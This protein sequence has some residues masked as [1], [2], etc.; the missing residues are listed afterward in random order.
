MKYDVLI[1]GG[2][3][4]GLVSAL[5]LSKEGLRVVVLEQHHKAGGNL[6]TF[7]RDG[8]IF[9]TGM[10]YLG[11][12]REGQYLHRYFKY[13]ELNDKLNLRQLDL[14]GF[15]TITFDGDEEEYQMSQSYAMFIDGL[16]Q[17]FPEEGKALSAYTRKIRSVIEQFPLYNISGTSSYHLNPSLLQECAAGFIKSTIRNPRLQNIL[18]GALSLYPGHADTTPLYVHACMRDSL[19]NSCWRPVDG[20]QQIADGLVK[21]IIKYGGEVMLSRRVKEIMTDKGVASGVLLEDGERISAKRIISNVHPAS[22]LQ[23]IGEGEIKKFYRRRIMRMK[24]TMGVFTV[25]ASL[26]ENSFPYLNKNYF[27]YTNNGVLDTTAKDQNWPENYYFYTP[28]TSRNEKYAESIVVMADMGYQEVKQWAGT[29]VNQRGEAYQAFKQE[30]AETMLRKLEERWPGI[31]S[32]I[33]KYYTSTPL[34]FMSYTATYEG[35]AYGVLKDCNDPL[36]SI[37]LPNTKISNLYFTGQNLNL[38]GI[39]GVTAAA[40]ITCSEILGLRYLTNKIANG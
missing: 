6:Q 16:Q 19:I 3:L 29:K 34:S 11:S 26:K 8:C 5:I 18:A 9:D 4:G 24:N 2:G 22:T 27:H 28:A 14:E 15:D 36:R 39:M 37:V 30:R 12:L 35:S 10:H 7:T 25:Y 20:S 23:M 17:H 38:H 21:G 33:L 1:I 32:K 13:L 31:N 40:V